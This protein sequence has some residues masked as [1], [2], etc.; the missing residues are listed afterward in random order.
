[1][2]LCYYIRLTNKGQRA[3]FD[4]DLKQTLLKLVDVYYEEK[5]GTNKI[6]LLNSITYEPFL[7]EYRGKQIEYFCQIL[8]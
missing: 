1:M 2:Y 5:I 8:E 6:G 7:E 4:S 3:N